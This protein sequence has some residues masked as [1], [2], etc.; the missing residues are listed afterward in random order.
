MH[1]PSPGPFAFTILF[2][3]IIN[4]SGVR[5]RPVLKKCYSFHKVENVK[6]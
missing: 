4:N 5:I 2:Y 1:G 3:I 6:S